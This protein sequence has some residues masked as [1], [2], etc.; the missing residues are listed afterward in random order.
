MGGSAN[1]IKIRNATTIPIFYKGEENT[2][3]TGTGPVIL[4][5]PVYGFRSFNSTV[6]VGNRTYYGIIDHIAGDWEVGIGTL[7]SST[8]LS[9]DQVLSS[10]NSGSLV[11]FGDKPKYVLLNIPANR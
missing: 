8:V 5:G 7:S 11:N 2:N 3:T 9:R 4:D 6:G 1:Y 10:T